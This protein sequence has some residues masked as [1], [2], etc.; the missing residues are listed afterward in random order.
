VSEPKETG[1][2]L[3]EEGKLTQQQLEQV[4]RR[5]QRL[6]IPQY[7]A[8]VD[9]NFASEEDTWRAL[10]RANGLEFVDPVVLELKRETLDL[11]PIKLIFHYRLLPLRTEDDGLVLAARWSRAI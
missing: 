3:F 6:K 1:E 4:R 10:A 2:L 5:Q 7:R 8:V 11:V 9:L